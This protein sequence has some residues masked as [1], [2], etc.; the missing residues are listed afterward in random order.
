MVLPARSE[1]SYARVATLKRHPVPHRHFRALVILVRFCGTLPRSE[2]GRNASFP[3]VTGFHRVRVKYMDVI[4]DTNVIVEDF[5][6]K[7]PQFTEL[8][9]YLKRTGSRLA[10]PTVVRDE[11]EAKF[12]EE[13]SRQIRAAKNSWENVRKLSRQTKAALPSV[14]VD[15]AVQSFLDRIQHPAPG[16]L[17]TTI[18]GLESVD[19]NDV[20]SRGIHRRRPASDDGEELRDVM[21]WLVAKHYAKTKSEEVAFISRDA[22]FRASKDDQQ[23]HPEL[24]SELDAAGIHISFHSDVANFITSHALDQHPVDESW[25]SR[26]IKFSVLRNAGGELLKAQVASWG[27]VDHAEIDSLELTKAIE[28]VIAE[29]SSYL[30]AEYKGVG[31]VRLT[32]GFY[33]TTMAASA[34][35]LSGNYVSQG[36]SAFLGPNT[37]ETQVWYS[38][39]VQPDFTGVIGG[40]YFPTTAVAAK[41]VSVETRTCIFTLDISARVK[42]GKLTAAQIDNLKVLHMSSLVTA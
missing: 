2:S 29:D 40:G 22:G 5:A 34:F 26:F 13:L 27:V 16:V 19:I 14:D 28:Y 32:P 37:P 15:L 42:A 17:E 38:P 24:R 30:E 35:E 9:G 1:V 33:A 25:L 23:L 4:L 36:M 20:V 8:M 31:T 39:N 3:S 12:R 41:T 21:V 10:I 11:A 6:F 7:R 18:L